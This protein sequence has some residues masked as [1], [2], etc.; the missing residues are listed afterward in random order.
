MHLI[1]IVLDNANL[2]KPAGDFTYHRV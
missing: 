2:I 1:T